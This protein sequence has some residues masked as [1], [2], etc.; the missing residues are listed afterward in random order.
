MARLALTPPLDATP[1]VID[2]VDVDSAKWRELAGRA[3]PPWSWIYGREARVLQGFESEVMRRARTTLVVNERERDIAASLLPTANVRVVG[4]GIDIAAFRPPG[5]PTAEPVVIFSGVM[6]YQPNEEGALWLAREVWP[7][8]QARKPGAR[9]V[10]AGAGPSR[11]MQRVA[12]ENP[13]IAITGAVDDMR[14]YLWRAAVGAAPLLLARGVQNKVIEAVAAGLPSVITSRVYA[15][16]PPEVTPACRVADDP[17]QFAAAI[18]ELLEASP[19]A[20]QQ[21]AARACLSGLDWSDRLQTLLPILEFACTPAATV[22][23]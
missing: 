8:V 22:Q 20:R 3:M 5:P 23:R 1:L 11:A 6:S 10:L 21:I 2:L 14:P 18:A 16:L 9:L 12:R 17:A 15:G 13:T 19:A 7:I 4:N